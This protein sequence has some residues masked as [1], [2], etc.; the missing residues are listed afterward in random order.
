MNEMTDEQLR[1]AVCEAS[2][3]TN[4]ATYTKA[5]GKY[6]DGIRPD[7]PDYPNPARFNLP[8]L[9]LDFIHEREKE[10]TGSIEEPDSE[11]NRYIH[12]VAD[13]LIKAG[14]SGQL[15]K[16]FLHA[17]KFQRAIAWLKVKEGK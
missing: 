11:W 5:S 14:E 9:T 13:E 15:R 17:N 4:I 6:P 8:D 16:G 12:A 7:Y 2:G 10:L 1:I 3:W